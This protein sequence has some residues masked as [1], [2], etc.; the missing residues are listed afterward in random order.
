MVVAP[1]ANSTI[2]PD[3]RIMFYNDDVMR[4]AVRFDKGEFVVVG[5]VVTKLEKK[6]GEQ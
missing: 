4:G 3:I 2:Q 5:D 6:L 1:V